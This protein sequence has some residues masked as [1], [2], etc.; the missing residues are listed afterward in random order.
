MSQEY[1]ARVKAKDI[2]VSVMVENILY[3]WQIANEQQ[4]AAGRQ[5]YQEAHNYAASLAEKYNKPVA[6]VAAVIAVLSPGTSWELNKRDAENVLEKGIL[7]VTSGYGVNKQKAIALLDGWLQPAAAVSALKTGSFW[8]NI[9]RPAEN[10]SVT[11]DRHAVR[12]ATGNHELAAEQ[13]V[14]YVNTPNKYQK[15]ATAYQLA[16]EK[17]GDILP[18]ELQAIT[19][20][21]V[22]DILGR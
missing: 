11:V 21:V 2:D 3:H 9:L 20:L 14:H 5:W 19:W 22:K 10:G 16:A 6:V 18:H 17:I 1:V 8:L 13:A 7:A 4:I 15:L 12:V